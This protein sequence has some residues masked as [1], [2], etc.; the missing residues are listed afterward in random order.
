MAAQIIVY[1]TPWCGYCHRLMREL[2]RERISYTEVDIEQR[3]E[4]AEIVMALN[5]GLKTVPTL[6][7]SDGTSLSNPSLARVKAHLTTVVS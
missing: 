3:P 5:D 6:V 7:F 4:A 1:S 2:D